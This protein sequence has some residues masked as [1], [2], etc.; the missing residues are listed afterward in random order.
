MY[1]T[2]TIQQE[3][4]EDIFFGQLVIIWARWFLIAAGIVLTLWTADTMTQ[5]ILGVVPVVALI[6]MNF[7]LHGRYLAER[8]A[9]PALVAATSLVDLAVV[10]VVVLFWPGQ[11]GLQSQFFILYYPIVLAFA[12]VM[13]PRISLGY[14]AVAVSAYVGACVAS[15]PSFLGDVELVETL[16]IRL[17]ALSAT[18]SLGAYY[19]RIQRNRRRSATESAGAD[20]AGVSS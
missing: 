8:P 20:L 13:S 2:R 12:F 1:G 11:G 4:A 5:V 17:I 14:T 19:W 15:G 16:V 6:A 7:Y 3:S 18:G 10:T 9:N